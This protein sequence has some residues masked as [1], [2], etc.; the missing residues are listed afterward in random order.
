MSTLINNTLSSASEQFGACATP[1]IIA[2]PRPVSSR[3]ASEATRA[4]LKTVAELT[5]PR[6][7]R[8]V[9]ITAGVGFVSAAVTHPWK[10]GELLIAAIGCMMGTA[11]SAAGANTLN[12]WWER[13]RDA[14][15][16][17]T[18]DRPLPRSLIEPR[19]ALSLGVALCVAGVLILWTTGGLLAAVLSA[20]TVLIYVLVYTPLKVVTP[21]SIL[22]GAIPGAI[23][24]MIGWA[25][26]AAPN[27][28]LAAR[29]VWLEW[30]GAA[31]WA[32]FGLMAVWQVPHFLAIAWM[33][34]DDYAAGGYKVLAAVD[35]T[36]RRTA[37][38]VLVWALV[39]L[40]CTLV[41]A[42][43][44]PEGVHWVY[45]A[46]AVVTGVAYIALAARFW[47]EPTR[48]NARRVFF[49][50]IIQLPLLLMVLVA[51]TLAGLVL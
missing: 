11:L 3:S 1:S 17:R 28:D 31:A 51:E 44:G 45:L 36:G 33:Y 8:L 10:T 30:P 19:M 42:V 35:P 20:L 41:P 23:P 26:A 43:S 49:A 40:P 21:L 14:V 5:K 46:A 6:I 50:S 38:S 32:L 48:P 25:A 2:I 12:Q 22:V 15:M 18:C 24:P 47:R 7:T 37:N 13:D 39:Q 29:L 27:G 34:R 9:T 4:A 16:P